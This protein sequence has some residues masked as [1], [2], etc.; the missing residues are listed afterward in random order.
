MTPAR[1]LLAIV[2]FAAAIG[3]SLY[4]VLTSWPT[5]EHTV[6]VSVAAH[7]ILLGVA[8]LE[9]GARGAKVRLSAASLRIPMTFGV[10]L[11]A[12]AGGDFGAA[13]TP[14][15]SGAEPARFLIMTEAGM[16]SANIILVIYA[17]LFLE[18]ISLAIVAIAMFFTFRDAGGIITGMASLVA[19]YAAFVL[20]TGAL[21]FVLARRGM[22]QTPPRWLARLGVH[23]AR[24]HQ[25]RN[26]LEQLRRGIEG[27]KDMRFGIAGIALLTSIVHII[28]RLAILPIIVYSFGVHVPAAP[29]ILWPI[30]LMYGSVVV[31][32]PAGGGFIE[33]AFKET[34]GHAIPSSIFGAS[35]I[36]WRFYTFYL[37][38]ILGAIAAGGTVLRALRPDPE[39]GDGAE[40]SGADLAVQHDPVR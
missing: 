38:I 19:M 9:L 34:L 7:G 32:V 31:A 35:L 39:D 30:A 22:N 27:M 14:A 24:W 25:F 23:G 40:E 26:V 37:Y 2:S 21:G 18:M 11:R 15:R 10:A 13:I 5:S 4:I 17:E 16:T 3:V 1:W 8:L 20:G 28:L 12:S 6:T 36:W 29:L 33:V